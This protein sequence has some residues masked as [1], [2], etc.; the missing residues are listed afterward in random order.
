MNNKTEATVPKRF[1]FNAIGKY[2]E[3]NLVE[4]TET[5]LN[6]VDYVVFGDRNQF[7]HYVDSL[8]LR[9]TILS[10][11]TSTLADYIV[12]NG[13]SLTNHIE[14][15]KTVNEKDETL[16]DLLYSI[17]LS[18]AKFGGAYI[19]VY[20]SFNGNIAALE[21]LDYTIVRSDEKNEKFYVSKDWANKSYGRIKSL[22]YNKFT[23]DGNDAVSIY[24]VKTNNYNNTYALPMYASALRSIET[25]ADIANYHFNS[26]KNNFVGGVMFDFCG[27]IP[28]DEEA[29]AI[30]EQILTKY[31]GTDNAG[32]I[33]INYS[34]DKEHSTQITQ[35]NTTDFND[36][37]NALIKTTKDDILSS[38]RMSGNL[39]GIHTENNGFNTEEF[40]SAFTLYQK[41]VVAPLQRKIERA[42]EKIFGEENCLNITPFQLDL[43][44]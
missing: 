41:T 42:F 1:Q 24:Y 14:F 38:F 6:N 21:C 19:A 28:T 20:R 5:T 12:G 10:V 8:Q 37:Y 36:K 22:V 3:K 9:S 31:S 39:V 17:S 29:E 13:C 18:I 34:T 27:G 2:Y 23:I 40:N 11:C 7:P 43:N 15:E 25:S 16:D 26:M 35:L 44:N 30:E 32:N 33:L 4:P